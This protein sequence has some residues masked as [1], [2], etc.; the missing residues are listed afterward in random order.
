MVVIFLRQI[1][2]FRLP[3]KINYS[4]LMLGVGA[5]SSVIHFI[6]SPENQDLTY[7]LKGSLI[8]MLVALMLF[9]VMNIM[10]QTQ[11]AENERIR[12][13]FTQVLIEQIRELKEFTANLEQRMTEY[14]KEEAELRNEFMAKFNKDIEALEKLLQNQSLFMERF[15]EAKKWHNELT[16]LFVN[17]TEFKLPELDSIVHKHIDMLRISEAEHYEH[18]TRFLKE[19]LGDKEKIKKELE[20]ILSEVHKV[21]NLSNKI[22]K[23]ISDEAIRRLSGVTRSFETELA[24]LKSHVEAL[25]TSLSEGENSISAIK[26]QGEYVM[27]QMIH[28]AQKM[29]TFEQK[30]ELVDMIVGKLVPIFEKIE[31][32]ENDYLGATTN[33]QEVSKEVHHLHKEQLQQL[34]KELL[35]TV[36]GFENKLEKILVEFKNSTKKEEM[37]DSLKILAKKAQMQKGGYTTDENL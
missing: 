10:H 33:L 20:N 12:M 27:E 11:M 1:S 22:A 34:N 9:I 31:Q 24:S 16:E 25:R 4:S 30:K 5:I 14:A 36:D 35:A 18:L 19:T 17:F 23:T 29:E 13:E 21:D 8:P 15:E 7:T 6:I 3:N 28:I 2:I 37:P 32:L 26:S